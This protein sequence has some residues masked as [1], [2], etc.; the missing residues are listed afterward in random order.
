[1]S[2]VNDAAFMGYILEEQRRMQI[3][4]FISLLRRCGDPNDEYEQDRCFLAA[5]F[6]PKDVLSAQEQRYIQKTLSR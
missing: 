5:G 3:D 1:M 6:S 4:R 2:I